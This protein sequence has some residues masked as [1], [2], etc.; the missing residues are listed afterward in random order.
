MLNVDQSSPYY[1][2]ENKASIFYAQSWA[3]THFLMLGDRMQHSKQLAEFL[4]L[5]G[6]GVDQQEAVKRT[7]GDLNDLQDQLRRYVAQMLMSYARV[8][9][10][11]GVD[12]KAFVARGISAAESVALRGDFLV[13]N[14]RYSEAKALLEEAV[15]LDSNHAPALESMGFLELQQGRQQEARKW[16]TQAVKLDSRSY[17]AHYYYAVMTMQGAPDAEAA[18]QVENNLRAAIKINPNFAPAHGTLAN[19]Y[20]M[21]G[22][23]L[24]EAHRLALQAV[25]LEPG[26]V[27]YFLNVGS[28]LLRLNRADD[29]VKV[30]ERALTLAKSREE[31]STVQSF[32]ETARH[33]QQYLTAQKQAEERK[34]T[35]EQEWQREWEKLK[36]ARQALQTA[37]D[38]VGLEIESGDGSL[39]A[40]ASAEGTITEAKCSPSASMK[41]TLALPSYKLELQARDYHQVELRAANSKLAGSGDPCKQIKG[42]PARVIYKVGTADAGEVVSIELRK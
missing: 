30:G 11:T 3:L 9:A 13:H 8:K 20:G 2:E 10:S 38:S 25:Q 35:A 1:N 40:R 33:Y 36:T 21:R 34:R 42:L 4:T 28:V 32:S 12:D 26:N 41:L 18:A 15:R 22:E 5:I 7:F 31:Q 39:P 23:H 27:H 14:Q 29:A 16:F 17:L 19:F 37:K 24:E 6:N